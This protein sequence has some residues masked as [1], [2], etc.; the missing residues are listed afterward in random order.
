MIKLLAGVLL[1]FLCLTCQ[2][3]NKKWI[4]AYGYEVDGPIAFTLTIDK[5]DNCIY[6]GEGVQTLFT[7]ICKG[8]ENDGKY[9][10]Y[11]IKTKEGVYYPEDWIDKA[12]PIITLLYKNG[13][14]YTDEGQLNKENKK[15][16]LLFK[17][18]K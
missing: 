1:L 16:K 9:E 5:A 17:K 8:K 14:L 7:V 2:N 6:E 13:K 12:K 10:I 11:W 18:D 15:P 3:N 4:G